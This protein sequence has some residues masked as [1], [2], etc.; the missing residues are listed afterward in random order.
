M[1]V[2]DIITGLKYKTVAR[3]TVEQE[4]NIRME[5]EAVRE[6]KEGWQDTQLCLWL[7][8]YGDLLRQVCN[9][10]FEDMYMYYTEY[11]KVGLKRFHENYRASAVTPEAFD[12][13]I[14]VYDMKALIGFCDAEERGAE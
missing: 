1:S 5:A 7:E 2:A 11:C 8:V 13:E 4:K 10:G 9:A 6:G 3:L 14:S 12:K